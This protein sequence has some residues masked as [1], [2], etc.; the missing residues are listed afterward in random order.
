M[1]KVDITI[2][3]AGVIGLAIAYVLSEFS[4]DITVIE[5]NRSFGQETS[6]RNS[7]VIHSGIYYPK[8]TLKE[9][10][11]IRGRE[12]LYEL[13]SKH[14]IPH[15]RLGKLIVASGEKD[16][17][18]LE[19]IYNNA[20][21]CGVKNLRFLD[22]GQIKR[23]EP[24]ID[25]EKALFSPDTGIVD[26]HSLMQFFFGR[27]KERNV[28]FAFSVEAVKIKRENSFYEI[29]VREPTGDNFSFQSGYV[30]NSAGLVSDKIAELAGIN[31]EKNNY[32]IHY[33]KGTYY[34][35][36]DPKKF[37]IEHLI[38]PPPKETDLGIHVTPDLAGGLRLGPDAEYV[39]DIEYNVEEAGRAKFFDS[40]SKLLVSL[41]QDDLIPD[42]AGIRPKL[43]GVGEGFRDFVIKD[44]ADLGLPRFIDLI[45][46]ESPGLTSCLAIAGLVKDLVKGSIND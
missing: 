27:A 24:R 4:K 18:K 15:R 41:E 12:L 10:T 16:I 20:S 5:R 40:V 8:G 35:I 11:C 23:L 17:G 31:I 28:N 6:S 29:T 44:E 21:E 32:K 30:I 34:R 26:T 22:K 38:Y 36:R 7:E 9:E 19:E 14:N 37:S 2:I 42:T 33:C 13:C 25:A 39:K 46:I 45:G 43:Q 3:G 1:E